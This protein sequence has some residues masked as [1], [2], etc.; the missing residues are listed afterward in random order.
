MGFTCWGF[1]CDA[2]STHI[3]NGAWSASFAH[4]VSIYSLQI[5]GAGLHDTGQAYSLKLCQLRYCNYIGDHADLIG[6]SSPI[7]LF[8]G[9]WLSVYLLVTATIPQPID[10]WGTGLLYVRRE[11]W[12]HVNPSIRH[13]YTDIHASSTS[14]TR[15]HDR[16][17]LRNI[18]SAILLCERAYLAVDIHPTKHP[19]VLSFPK[20]NIF[21]K[22]SNALPAPPASP[23]FRSPTFRYFHWRTFKPTFADTLQTDPQRFCNPTHPFPHHPILTLRRCWFSTHPH[24]TAP[25]LPQIR[26]SSL[27]PQSSVMRRDIHSTEI[28]CMKT[29]A[30]ADKKNRQ[31]YTDAHPNNPSLNAKLS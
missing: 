25:T 6:V 28:T 30:S 9:I 7:Q 13:A 27:N 29:N 11:G 14:P 10:L 5:M 4:Q 8:Q 20:T 21:R 15:Y 22:L 18:T 16:G 17:I 24:R 1:C 2:G 3:A 19:L 31:D 26:H 12:T 23:V